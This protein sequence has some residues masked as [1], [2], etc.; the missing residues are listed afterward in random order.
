MNALSP[1]LDREEY[2]EQAYF[3][4]TYRERLEGGISSQEILAAIHEEVL[5][6][7]KL[8][9]AIDFLRGEIL[10]TGRICDGMTRLPHYFN[11]F[12]TFVMTRAE[13]ERAK[14]DQ[15]IALHI[16][17]R[18]AEYRAKDPTPAGLFVY[19]FECVARNRLGYE[20]GL[21]AM[22]ADP[23]FGA[24]W[25]QWIDRVRQSLGSVEF[26]DLIYRRSQ[27]YVE[28]RYSRNRSADPD[29]EMPTPQG[30]LFG[31]QEGRIA[32]ANRG[33]DPLLMFA[34]LQRQLDYPS[35]PRAVPRG[36]GPVIHPIVDTRLKQL[37]E[38]IKLLE[39]E[40]RSG[41]IDLS[42]F[43]VKPVETPD[44]NEDT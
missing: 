31:R 39:S 4:R 33:K 6:T 29:A 30:L 42:Q 27:Q 19:Q 13:E 32:K 37:E 22:A 2:I 16:L 5:A 38:R 14:F 21:T 44:A 18:E 24:D 35:V 17:E 15:K 9:L 23:M 25:K 3:F 40:T 36:G 11:A 26:A 1:Q 10:L 28:D 8:P 12:Q 7:T 43:A 34:A 41:G 20:S